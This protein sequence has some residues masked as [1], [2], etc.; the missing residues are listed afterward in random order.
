M[1]GFMEH[2]KRRIR[3]ACS[4]RSSTWRVKK[5]L[6]FD[7]EDGISKPLVEEIVEEKVTLKCPRVKK[8]FKSRYSEQHRAGDFA[9]KRRLDFNT[10]ACF[11][12]PP[13]FNET[14]ETRNLI[15]QEIREKKRSKSDERRLEWER[16]M[17][18]NAPANPRDAEIIRPQYNIQ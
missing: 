18:K 2:M 17:S 4:S 10:E 5:R 14:E 6:N 8:S 1:A 13:S 3:V 7:C 15:S 11:F 12:F 9:A 16:M